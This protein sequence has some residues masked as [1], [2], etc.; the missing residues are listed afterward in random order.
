MCLGIP[1]RIVEIVDKEKSLA[2]VDI[3][4]VRRRINIACILD[5]ENSA[6]S[7]IGSWVL[8]HVGFAMS[9]IEEEE[10]LRTLSLIA[11]LGD[12]PELEALKESADEVD[13]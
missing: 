2:T 7:C 5:E 4:G 11:K 1:G 12:D 8:I 10:A 6:E 3:A 13:R 9:K